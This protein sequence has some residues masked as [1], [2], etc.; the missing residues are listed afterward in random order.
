MRA[1]AA[2]LFVVALSAGAALGGT[3][4]LHARLARTF[5]LPGVNS[6]ASTAMVV[7]LPSGRIVFARNADLSLEPASNE[8][9]SVTYAALTEL[10]SS[11]RWPTEVLGEGRRVGST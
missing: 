10:G 6:A 2:T 8:K 1:L 3:G 7:E 4:S 11:Y 9:L 5:H